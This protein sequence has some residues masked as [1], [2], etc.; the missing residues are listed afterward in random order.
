MFLSFLLLM[1]AF[2]LV[3]SA[4][5]RFDSLPGITRSLL[6]LLAAVLTAFVFTIEF[7]IW[8]KQRILEFLDAIE[9]VPWFVIAAVFVFLVY[10]CYRIFRFLAA[11]D[12]QEIGRLFR[13]N[14]TPHLK[15]MASDVREAWRKRTRWRILPSWKALPSWRRGKDD[16][17]QEPKAGDETG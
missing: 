13:E 5:A 17:E 15:E 14:V 8:I 1:I 16:E 11:I 9:G 3:L 2:S 4:K 12:R 7:F 6:L 10:V